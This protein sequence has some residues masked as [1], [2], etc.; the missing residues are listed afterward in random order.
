MFLGSVVFCEITLL[1][2]YMVEEY[3]R[4]TFTVKI[5]YYLIGLNPQDMNQAIEKVVEIYPYFKLQENIKRDKAHFT[6]LIHKRGLHDSK[7]C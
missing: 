3:F 6:R 4:R 7:S 5:C 1:H 2:P